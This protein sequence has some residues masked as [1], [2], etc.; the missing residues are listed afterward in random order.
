RRLADER[1]FERD[2]HVVAQIGAALAA[3]GRTAL[4]ATAHHVAE[5]VLEDVGET[6]AAEAACP[7]AGALLECGMAE[8]VIG[9]AALRI[10]QHVVGFADFAEALF[11]ARIARIA[12]RMELH[13]ELPIGALEL[14]LVRSA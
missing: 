1:L 6:A 2:F 9:G 11:G 3:T 7:R 12:I 13:R 4:A 5:D 8:P 10:L 14:L